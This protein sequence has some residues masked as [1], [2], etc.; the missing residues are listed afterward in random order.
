IYLRERDFN[1]R[2][3]SYFASKFLVLA[4][5]ALVQ[6][7]LLFG[8]VRPWCRPEGSAALQWVA[9]A[10]PAVAGTAIGLFLS[11]LARAGEVAAAPLPIAV[12]P[13]I[14]LAGV[15]APLSGLAEILA[16]GLVTVYWARQALESLLPGGDLALLGR[17]DGGFLVPW[18][19]VLAQA[20]AGAAA[21]V[22]V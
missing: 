14:I 7:T 13:Q 18:T 8:I 2:V 19:V 16:K 9:L 4:L 12:I 6:V 20:A 11:A 10:A 15:V 3:G 22:V 5:I 17:E 21:T 1:L